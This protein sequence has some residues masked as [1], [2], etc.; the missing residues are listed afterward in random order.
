MNVQS[1]AAITGYIPWICEQS[2][3]RQNKN[4]KDET[5]DGGWGMGGIIIVNF[6]RTGFVGVL[7]NE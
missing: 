1:S 4:I 3:L 7:F 2:I 6:G 5:G